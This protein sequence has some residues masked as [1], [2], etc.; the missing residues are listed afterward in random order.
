MF[1]E[2]NLLKVSELHRSL[3]VGR[4][5]CGT[6]NGILCYLLIALLQMFNSYGIIL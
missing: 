6:P 1:V 3:I 2:K 5:F 4:S